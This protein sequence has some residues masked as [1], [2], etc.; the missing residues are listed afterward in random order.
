MPTTVSEPSSSNDMTLSRGNGGNSKQRVS[1]FYNQDVGHYYYGAIH[2]MKP[3]R[4]KLAHHL[5]L[6]YGLYREMDVYESTLATYEELQ[7]FHTEEYV[8]FLR[9]ITPDLVKQNNDSKPITTDKTPTPTVKEGA[10]AENE[11]RANHWVPKF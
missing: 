7:K 8:S 11:Q 9:K 5:I 1:Y 4:V 10:G 3:F 6:T 2:P